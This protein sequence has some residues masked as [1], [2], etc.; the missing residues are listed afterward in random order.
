M[1]NDGRDSGIEEGQF[2][3]DIVLMHEI[4]FVYIELGKFWSISFIVWYE[5]FF[6]FAQRYQEEYS[7]VTLREVELCKK[8]NGEICVF[9]RWT[10][11]LAFKSGRE[12]QKLFA[13]KELCINQSNLASQTCGNSVV[14]LN[15]LDTS[16]LNFSSFVT[17]ICNN[18]YY[19]S[20]ISCIMKE[21][22]YILVFF[23][24]P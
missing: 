17:N 13:K 11:Y 6:R 8:S 12:I 2:T 5:P 22:S 1:R 3:N 24:L 19:Q 21:T 18:I 14:M 16:F 15:I 10:W 20:S 7:Y 4:L 23:F 9:K